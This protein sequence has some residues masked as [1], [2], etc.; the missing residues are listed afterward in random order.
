MIILNKD[1]TPI[2]RVLQHAK[3]DPLQQ[4]YQSFKEGRKRLQSLPVCPKC[5]RTGFR[6][7]GW[8]QNKTMFCPH[9]GFRGTATH[10]LSAYIKE[11]LYK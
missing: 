11:G 2:D 9:C 5:E 4:F 6:D 10:V 7:R 3:S 1:G 8:S